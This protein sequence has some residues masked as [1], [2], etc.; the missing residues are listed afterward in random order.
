MPAVSQSQ[1]RLFAQAL[2]H[3][4]GTNPDASEEVRKLSD[5]MSEEQLT[6]F[7]ATPTKGLPDK[8]ASAAPITGPEAIAHALS[9]LDMT[10]LEAE[11]HDII[12][13]K[14]VSKRDGAVKILNVLEGSSAT[15]CNPPIS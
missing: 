10:K 5:S 8:A 9:K 2:S 3:K 4:R 14:K 7:A 12:K 6:H 13:A 11:Q 15:T 1:Q